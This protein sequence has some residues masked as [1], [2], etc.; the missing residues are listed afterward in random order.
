MKILSEILN[1]INYKEFYGSKDIEISSIEY[2]SRKCNFNSCFVAIKGDKSDGHDFINENISNECSLII[3]EKHPSIKL[4]ESKTALIIVDNSRIALAEI[5]HAFY[6]EPS[7]KLKIIG[8]T[9]TNGKTTTTFLIKSILESAGL[10]AGIIGTTG[11]YFGNTKIEASLTTPESSDLAKIFSDLIEKKAEYAI[12]E[13]SSIALMQHRLDCIHFRAACFTNLTLDHLDY[14][15][16]MDNYAKAKKILFN[17]LEEN[18]IAVVNN[19]DP[20][21][22][23]MVNNIKCKNII[24]V[25]RAKGNNYQIIKEVL[26]IQGSSFLL[27]SK[28][29]LLNVRTPLIGRFNVDNSAMAASVCNS[30]KIDFG[31]IQNGL[32]ISSGAPGRMEKVNFPNG[33]IGIV[34]YSHTPDA[35]EK[36]LKSCRDSLIQSQSKG[37]VIC[38][39]GCGG[40]RDKSK[41]PI[42]GKIAE[43][44]SDH[45]IITNDNPRTEKPKQIIND[46]LSG[47]TNTKRVKVI[48]DRSSAIT[49]AYKISKKGDIILIAGKGHENYQ[50][51][52]NEKFHFDDMEELIKIRDS[53]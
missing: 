53:Y 44:N 17:M 4:N 6:D 40:D 50:I 41:R 8:I 39:F 26:S 34:D 29:N 16:N 33:S 42:M 52:G 14:H 23:F 51:I 37:S 10:K 3:C 32:C 45:T 31:A 43:E 27:F 21:S 24:K 18:S 35:L 1:K 47:I 22:D 5:S 12:M 19:D 30:L 28:E 46:I 2:D 11:I 15:G 48:E 13:V 38:V 36:A 7:K 25:G 20:N 9:G 49:E